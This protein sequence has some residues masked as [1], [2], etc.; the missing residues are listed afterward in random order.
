[1]RL[2]LIGMPGAGKTTLGRALAAAYEVPFRDLDAE[3]VERESRSVADIFAAEGEAY[4]RT[5]EAAVLREVVAELPEVVLATGGGTPCF[6]QNLE[7]LLDTGY[8]LYL[9]VP[10][11]EL[12]ARLQRAA[13]S[14]PL[15]AAAAG[16]A[17][18]EARLRETLAA[19]QQFYSRAPLRC[20]GSSCSV[21][22][23]QGLLHQYRVS[24]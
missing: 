6:H 17:A 13:A 8:T 7:V 12:V 2:Y 18:L 14:R 11:E 23:V 10:V 20:T 3:I 4:F 22:A 1:M 21:A 16:P 24:G 19:R 15:L 5:R 9:E